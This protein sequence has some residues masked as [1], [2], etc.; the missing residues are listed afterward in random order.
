MAGIS[1]IGSYR[2]VE[3]EAR[4]QANASGKLFRH[5]FSIAG[6]V[7]RFIEAV[8]GQGD[9]SIGDIALKAKLSHKDVKDIIADLMAED[10]PIITLQNRKITL[11]ESE[12]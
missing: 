3:H 11:M 1:G 12:F 6:H 4:T 2:L 8:R 5:A 7:P 10:E 9:M